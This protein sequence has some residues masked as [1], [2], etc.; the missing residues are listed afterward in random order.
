MKP[1][2]IFGLPLEK[3]DGVE[4]SHSL[5]Y[6]IIFIVMLQIYFMLQSHS[7]HCNFSYISIMEQLKTL[8]NLYS[9]ERYILTMNHQ[10]GDLR[11]YVTFKVFF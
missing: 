9:N 10:Q 1:K 7:Q 3:M 2:I 11:F 5:V 4:R 6:M 8:M